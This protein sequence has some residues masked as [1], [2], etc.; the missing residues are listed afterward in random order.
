MFKLKYLKS[1]EK[2]T[3]KS[4]QKWINS[5]I[6]IQWVMCLMIKNDRIKLMRSIIIGI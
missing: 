6:H 1:M 2:Q 3:L 5:T 4:K